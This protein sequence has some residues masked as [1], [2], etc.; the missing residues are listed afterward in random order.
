M[1]MQGHQGE[2]PLVGDVMV[3]GRKGIKI[4]LLGHQ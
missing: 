1:K 2:L 3:P 4:M